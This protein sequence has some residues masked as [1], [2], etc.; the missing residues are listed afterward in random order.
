MAL[1]KYEGVNVIDR[2]TKPSVSQY[3]KEE[4]SFHPSVNHNEEMLQH[5]STNFLERQQQLLRVKTQ[6]LVAIEE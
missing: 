5:L 4:Y 3:Q 2:L 1:I 6:R